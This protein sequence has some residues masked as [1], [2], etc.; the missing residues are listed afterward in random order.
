MNK[1]TENEIELFAIE[2]LVKLG[3][4]YIYAPELSRNYEEVLLKERLVNALE[5]I[6]PSLSY[7]TLQDAVK[8]IQ[9]IT[10]SELL[11][12]NETF[13]KL[14]VEGGEVLVLL[15]MKTGLV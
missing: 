6:N 14:L 13:H 7:S 11:S 2:L 8:Q 1:I 4:T 15:L 9:R 5:T 12:D 3:Y 10:S